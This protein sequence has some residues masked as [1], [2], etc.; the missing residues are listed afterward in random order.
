VVLHLLP[1]AALDPTTQIDTAPLPYRGR[2]LLPLNVEEYRSRHNLDGFLTHAAYDELMAPTSY[3]QIFRSGAME[4]VESS[5]LEYN[6][7]HERACNIKPNFWIASTA[8]ERIL[9]VA[10]QRFLKV[11]QSL[12]L[13]PPIFVMLS[14]VGVKGYGVLS[15]WSQRE[16][17][18]RF[19][20]DTLLLPDAVANGFDDH[21]DVLL[22]PAFD[23]IWQATGFERCRH[24]RNNGRWL[25][26][27]DGQPIV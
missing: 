22:Q 14:L 23:A 5:L 4:A 17:S 8:V 3:L 18:Y 20:R 25:D 11:E 2:E 6:N 13:E 7:D 19:D 15:E 10:L 21:P 1:I 26:R 9:I 24:Y 27:A 16:K 12:G